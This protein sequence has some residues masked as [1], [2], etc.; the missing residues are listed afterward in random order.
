MP[1]SRAKKDESPTETELVEEIE[2][3]SDGI[4][5]VTLGEAF[6]SR[7]YLRYSVQRAIRHA[8]DKG[9]IELG[10]RLRLRRRTAA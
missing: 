3:H 7:G 4:D 9:D 10:P 1:G 6:E 5:A 8:L 2:R